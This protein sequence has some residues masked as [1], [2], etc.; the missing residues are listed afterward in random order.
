MLGSRAEPWCPP[1]PGPR[2]PSLPWFSGSTCEVG[3]IC[4]L[5]LSPAISSFALK[6]I[7][8]LRL[9]LPSWKLML[10]LRGP[11]EH[12]M[13]IFGADGSVGS[14]SKGGILVHGRASSSPKRPHAPVK[15]IPRPCCI[16]CLCFAPAPISVG[17]DAGHTQQLQPSDLAAS[18]GT[19]LCRVW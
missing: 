3:S 14:P 16:S 5:L 8:T 10:T 13:W 9:L 2:P 15:V 7:L 6:F 17:F 12:R 19:A 1:Q 4:Y 18:L 11:T